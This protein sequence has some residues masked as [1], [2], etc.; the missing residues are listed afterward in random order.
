MKIAQ[1]C[2]I[3]H[4]VSP[5][6]QQGIYGVVGNLSDGLVDVGHDVTIYSAGDAISKAAVRSIVPTH[7][8]IRNLSEKEI[9]RENLET[10]S[11]CY[12]RAAEHDIIHSHFSMMS[13]YFSNLV[14]TP[15]VHSLH[16]PVPPDL[17]AHLYKYPKERFISFSQAQRKLTPKLNWVA[18]VYHGIDTKALEYREQPEDYFLYLGRITEQKGVHHAIA[19]AKEAGVRLYIAGMTY[20]NEGY[21]TKE[22]EPHID[23]SQ[24]RFLGQ[25]SFE[26][27]MLLLQGARALL[28]PTLYDEVFGLVIIEALA[29]GTPTIGFANGAVPEIVKHGRTGY[30][31]DSVKQ[32]TAAIQKIDKISRQACRDRAEKFFSIEK[33]VR[34]YEN[35]YERVIRGQY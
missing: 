10:I 33:M 25:A 14:K 24:I 12:E 8:H 2:S 11:L 28:F 19:A 13:C 30:V 35:V 6:A 7:A 29:C 26:Q 32:M 5:N 27:K 23:G 22:I 21:W 31:V 15:S 18:T 34:G 1:L 9:L 17:L 3:A 16:S 4:R 20:P